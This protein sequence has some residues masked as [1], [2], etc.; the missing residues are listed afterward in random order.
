MKIFFAS[1]HAGFELKDKLISFVKGLGYDDVLDKG[2]LAFDPADD[3]PD[4]IKLVAEEVSRDPENARGFV[5]GGGGQGEAIAANRF[6]GVRAAVFY[7][8]ATAKDAVDIEGR[9]S[10]DPYEGIRLAR[11]H[12]NA[13]VLSLAARFV[14]REEAET[15]VRIFLETSFSEEERHKRRIAKIDPSQ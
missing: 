7:G 13:N 1:D 10:G 9:K 11:E 12:N 14:S 5:M 4:F 2:P 15:A 8:P 6:R 3:Y